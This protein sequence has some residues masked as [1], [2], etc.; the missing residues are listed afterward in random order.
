MHHLERISREVFFMSAFELEYEK[1]LKKGL[2]GDAAIIAAAE[3]ARIT[4][5]EGMLDYSDLNKPPFAK[6]WYGRNGYQ[7]MTY[8]SQMLGFIFQNFY[9]A[10]AASGL[11][12]AQKREA[13]IKFYDVQAMAAIMGGVTGVFGYTAFIALVDGLKGVIGGDD[14]DD[15]LLGTSFDLYIRKSF[16]PRYFGGDSSIARQMGLDPEFAALLSRGVEFGLPSALT[17]WNISGSVSLDGLWFQDSPDKD[18]VEDELYFFI[19]K[20]LAGPVLSVGVNWMRGFK[21]AAEGD[22]LRGLETASPAF[23]K[24]PME[25][26]RFAREGSKQPGV[27]GAVIAPEEYYTRWK[28]FGQSLGFG[29]TEVAQ[30]Q[31]ARFLF[32]KE[33]KRVGEEKAAVLTS[34]DR[35]IIK[36]MEAYSKYGAESEQVA[37]AQAKL[38]EGFEAVNAF[39]NQYYYNA[40][41]KD[42]IEESLRGRAKR[43]EDTIKGLYVPKWASWIVYPIMMD[44][45]PQ[46]LPEDLPKE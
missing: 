24:E 13:A 8:R 27:E 10:F 11:T 12:S 14:E 23:I 32:D 39:N 2:T 37:D 45:P 41:T 44:S 38:T 29:S 16:I 28:L 17:D 3:V 18:S 21:Q 35:A 6:K 4:T 19:A 20:T 46:P 25:A 22:F 42:N 40:I 7:F 26:M 43:R 30:G 15:P 1:Q 36:R 9:R 31:E 33:I 5:N 34:L